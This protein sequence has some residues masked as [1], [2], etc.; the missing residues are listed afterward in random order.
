MSETTCKWCEEAPAVRIWWDEHNGP[1][2][3]CAECDDEQ[4]ADRLAHA[5]GDER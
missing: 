3:V 1:C 4:S 5:K 2:A